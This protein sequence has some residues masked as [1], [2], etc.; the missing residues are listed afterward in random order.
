MTSPGWGI[1]EVP[2]DLKGVV[3]SI[4]PVVKSP[5]LQVTVTATAVDSAAKLVDYRAQYTITNLGP[6]IAK[7]LVLKV[8]A[9]ALGKGENVYW[10]PERTVDLGD[11]AEGQAITAD[12]LMMIPA[13]EP[14][15]I[16]C[17]VSGE[18]AD[19]AQAA[20]GDFVAG[21]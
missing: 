9:M 7:H 20:T 4:T 14:S 10:D 6:G 15:R 11:L 2:D 8:R 3:P 21:T 13:E 17:I 16:V 5:G 18:N 19:P 12:L 1:G